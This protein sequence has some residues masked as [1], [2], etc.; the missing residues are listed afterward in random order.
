MV[1]DQVGVT[2]EA[3]SAR[4]SVGARSD[5]RGGVIVGLTEAHLAETRLAFDGVAAQYDRANTDNELLAAMRRRTLAALT[6]HVPA[7]ARVLDLGCGPGTDAE[8]LARAGYRVTAIDWSPAMV[9]ET[10]RRVARSGLADR[11]EVHHLGIHEL[12]RLPPSGWDAACSDF[13]PLNCVPDL[14]D[15]ARLIAL[16]LRPGGILVASVIGRVCPWEIGLYLARGDWARLRVRFASGFAAVPL[17]GRR[18][19]TRYYSPREFER[20][21]VAAGF[22]SVSRRTL[23]LLV[24]PP[25]LQAFADRHPTLVAVLQRIEDHVAR[26][27]GVRECG[28]HFLV[29]MEKAGGEGR[30]EC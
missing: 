27:P 21:F 19:W 5:D 14:H 17:N 7:G 11:V 9:G 29:V 4:G 16:R 24:P 13:G 25:Y 8:P 20:T 30:I 3:V 18:V 26:Y 2:R 12:D 22:R 1:G 6:A 15:A 23:G 28:D 10:R